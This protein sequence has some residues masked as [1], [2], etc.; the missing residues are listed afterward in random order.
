MLH[1]IRLLK[2][3]SL[4]I[5]Y[6]YMQCIFIILTSYIPAL[7]FLCPSVHLT[8][9]SCF[10]FCFL[11]S[12][13]NPLSAITAAI[14]DHPLGHDQP[15]S[16]NTGP[17]EN[18]SSSLC[19]HELPMTQVVNRFWYNGLCYANLPWILPVLRDKNK[20]HFLLCISP[21]DILFKRKKI[22]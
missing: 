21:Q 19:S 17:Q 4:K 11:F 1:Q 12:F 22:S 10:C 6:M 15:T 2:I 3:Y 9:N 7:T 18:D 16:N 14:W 5:S 13:N 8:H 20:C